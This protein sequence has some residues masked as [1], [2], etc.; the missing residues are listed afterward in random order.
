[1]TVAEVHEVFRK[2]ANGERKHGAF[3]TKFA[4]ALMQA[5]DIEAG[6]YLRTV[7]DGPPDIRYDRMREQL[8]KM[9]GKDIAEI[10]KRC[11]P[12]KVT[13]AEEVVC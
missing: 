7:H 9:H 1:M 11:Q 12:E 5:D 6:T 3:L 2:I 13:I 8:W 10:S 4:E